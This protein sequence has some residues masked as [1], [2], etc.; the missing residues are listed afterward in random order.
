MGNPYKY[1]TV[2]LYNSDETDC[3]QFDSI[4]EACE[5]LVEHRYSKN[6]TSAKAGLYAMLNGK[7]RQ[8]KGLTITVNL[9][10]TI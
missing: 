3:W 10:E 7:T 1:T 9:N 6:I 4:I 8:Y 5:W 2:M